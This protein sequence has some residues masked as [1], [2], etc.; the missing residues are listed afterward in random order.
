MPLDEATLNRQL[1]RAK[2]DLARWISTLENKGVAAANRRK[3]ATWRHLNSAC[4]MIKRRLKA[5]AAVKT[6]DEQVAQHKSEK[7]AAA[8]D[9][10]DPKKAGKEPKVGKEKGA[11][12]KADGK[13]P[14]KAEKAAKAEK[15]AEPKEKKKKEK[16]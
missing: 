2:E 15:G 1:G 12:K 16:G 10:K 8:V 13:K 6:R 9:Q 4:N 11:A 3:D 5:A 14:D 7:L